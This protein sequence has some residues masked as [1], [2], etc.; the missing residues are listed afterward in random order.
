LQTGEE[1]AKFLLL[2][3]C[4]Q[5]GSTPA[6]KEE[7][8][9]QEA[10]FPGELAIPFGAEEAAI[11]ARLYRGLREP[12]GRE[13]DVVIA[14]CAINYDAALWILNV[15]DFADMPGLR[16]Y[17]AVNRWSAPQRQW[18]TVPSTSPKNVFTGNAR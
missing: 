8:A 2:A 1:R 6:L 3:S 15:P 11:A 18:P 16:L 7:L 4:N 14:S 10:L 17:P 9:A 12:R 5:E 13:L